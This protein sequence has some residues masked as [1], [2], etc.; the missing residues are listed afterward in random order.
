MQI[1]LDE[2]REAEQL[3]SKIAAHAEKILPALQLM[4]ETG[5]TNVVIPPIMDRLLERGQVTKILK[6]GSPTVTHL[7]NAKK[8][9]PLYIAGSNSAKFR[10]SE[11][12]R[13]IK[14]E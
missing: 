6:V 12:E 4:K 3:M 11:V 1:N 5:N 13:L 2:L 10:L 8:L 14:K 7:I 9:T